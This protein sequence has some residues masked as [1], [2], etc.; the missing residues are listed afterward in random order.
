M[1]DDLDSA[2]LAGAHSAMA[3]AI[4]RG[5]APAGSNATKIPDVNQN[6]VDYRIHSWA[7]RF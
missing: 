4:S 1:A 3:H 2:E 6:L 7:A 5:F